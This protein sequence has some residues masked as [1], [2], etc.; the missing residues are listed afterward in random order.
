MKHLSH[1]QLLSA[2]EGGT[3]QAASEHVET[4]GSCRARVDD[5]RQMIGLTR[6]ERIPEPSPLFWDHFSERVR[7][8]VALEPQPRSGWSG[9]GLQWTASVIGA[10]AIIVIGF[11]V[12]MRTGQPIPAVPSETAQ[13]SVEPLASLSPLNDGATWSFM[14][15]LASQMDWD[16]AGEAG[17]IARP[18]SAEQALDGLSLDEQRVVVELL[19]QEIQKSKI[20]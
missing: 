11:A 1:D 3:E 8:A 19:Q 16:A 4:C 13:V 14:G 12:T 18:G 20:L 2:A 5:L 9:F 10:L 15:D 7:E 17:F 6:D